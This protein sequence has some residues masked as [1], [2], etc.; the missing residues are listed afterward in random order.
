[1]LFGYSG[2]RSVERRHGSRSAEARPKLLPLL[3][4][5]AEAWPQA[6]PQ[7]RQQNYPNRV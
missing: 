6:R 1:M 3:S 4:C 2:C 5:Q 7:K